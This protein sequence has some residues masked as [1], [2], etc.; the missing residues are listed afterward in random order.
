MPVLNRIDCNWILQQTALEET[1][2][3]LNTELGPKSQIAM[4]AIEEFKLMTGVYKHRP[5]QNRRR[6]KMQEDAQIRNRINKM[7]SKKHKTKV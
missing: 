1:P 3:A 6:R 2:R 7:K 5:S 4:S